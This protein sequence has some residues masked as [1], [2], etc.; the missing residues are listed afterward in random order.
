MLL[1]P[2]LAYWTFAL[3]NLLAVVACAALGVRAIRRRRLDAH[4]RL[5]GAAGC[6]VGLFLA[7][8]AGKLWWLGREDRSAWSASDL[9]VLYVHEA[10]I[11][12]MLVAGCV[13]GLRAFR[14]RGSLGP[15]PGLSFRGP[16]PGRAA[17]R[18]AGWAAVIASA[19]AL[20]TAAAVL[21]GMYARAG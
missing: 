18:R 9:A 19:L 11:A 2:R 7:S 15:G 21:A 17:H 14:F 6:L 12:V 1:D 13:A 8:Y 16:A 20:G 5:M 10:C 3:A 4:R